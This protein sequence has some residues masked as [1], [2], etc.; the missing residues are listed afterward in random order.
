MYQI[1]LTDRQL[2]LLGTTVFLAL[3]KQKKCATEDRANRLGYIGELASE[4]HLKRLQEIYKILLTET[5]RT[6]N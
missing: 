6:G 2:A 5:K 3:E 1:T 4:T